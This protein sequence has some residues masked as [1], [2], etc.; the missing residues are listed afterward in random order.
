MLHAHVQHGKSS[1]LPLPHSHDAF[2]YPNT[3]LS[4]YIRIGT[5]YYR[6]NLVGTYKSTEYGPNPYIKR[7][8]SDKYPICFSSTLESG[9]ILTQKCHVH[10]GLCC[11]HCQDQSR[12]G[13]HLRERI[14]FVS[15]WTKVWTKPMS[16]L[17][18]CI[19]HRWTLIRGGETSQLFESNRWQNIKCCWKILLPT[20]MTVFLF[21]KFSKLQDCF[22]L[23]C[24]YWLL[25]VC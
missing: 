14:R 17:I 24:W 7:E 20:H 8:K 9:L 10:C 18:N 19:C 25:S 15:L 12:Y 3:V 23:I 16:C 22:F 21:N 2:R 1:P 13:S 6:W 11:S 4:D 5:W